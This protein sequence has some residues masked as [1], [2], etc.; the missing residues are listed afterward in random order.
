[1]VL[2]GAHNGVLTVRTASV[3]GD[4]ARYRGQPRRDAILTARFG[5]GEDALLLMAVASGA[6]AAEGA[7]LAARDACRWMAASVG[8]SHEPLRVEPALAARIAGRCS[9]GDGPPG[10][11]AFLHDVQTRV[12]GYADDR[13]AVAVWDA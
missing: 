4:S 6:R 13:T 5:A 3:R 1:T 10:L 12:K 9:G 7:H 11:A 2:D 8:R